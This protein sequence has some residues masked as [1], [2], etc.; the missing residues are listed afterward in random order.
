MKDEI[1]K[2]KRIKTK[3]LK[4][5]QFKGSLINITANNDPYESDNK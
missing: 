2:M 5:S 4:N 1:I 3:T